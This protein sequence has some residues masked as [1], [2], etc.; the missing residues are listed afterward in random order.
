MGNFFKDI[1]GKVNKAFSGKISNYDINYEYYKKIYPDWDNY[2][3]Q[4]SME[5][6]GI[7]YRF[8]S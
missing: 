6:I 2:M 5:D 4:K 1:W 8:L 7:V 3:L